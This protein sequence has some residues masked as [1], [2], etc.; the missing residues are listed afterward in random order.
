MEKAKALNIPPGRIYGQL[1]RGETV[2]LPDGRQIKGAQLCGPTEVGRKM[3]YCTDTVYC[4]GA[5]SL[6]QDTDVLIHEATFSHKDAELAFQRMHSTSTMAA[7]VALAAQVK[8]LIMTHFSPRYAPGNDIELNDLLQE[9]RA[10]FPN[11]EMAYDF[12]TYE[13]PRRREKELTQAGV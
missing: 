5:V 11:T 9:A 2:T 1:K 8:L 6:A 12:T 4:D 7:Q 13:I 10:I 3:A